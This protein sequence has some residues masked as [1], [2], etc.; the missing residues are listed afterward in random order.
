MCEYI[1]TMEVYVEYDGS[2]TVFTV[3]E[4]FSIIIGLVMLLIILAIALAY[5]FSNYKKK[6]SEI[7]LE[8]S[9]FE[10]KG[11]TTDERVNK[12]NT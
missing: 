2:L 5:C 7:S 1:E 10:S 6:E 9:G 3:E 12:L 11:Y 8:I 4:L